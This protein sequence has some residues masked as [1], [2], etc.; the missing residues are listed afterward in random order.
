ML[1]KHPSEGNLTTWLEQPYEGYS[2]STRSIM[3][4]DAPPVRQSHVLGPDGNQL[5]VDIPRQKIGYVLFH[6]EETK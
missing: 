4:H 2:D 5:L 6:Q 1:D 3:T